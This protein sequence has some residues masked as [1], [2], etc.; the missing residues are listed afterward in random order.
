LN[1]THTKPTNKCVCPDVLHYIFENDLTFS[2]SNVDNNISLK[3]A[4]S[5]FF[6]KLFP[7]LIL[8]HNSRKRRW[9]K[10][11]HF[12][13]FWSEFAE[14]K[15]LFALSTSTWHVTFHLQILTNVFSVVPTV[16]MK[17]FAQ[18]P[19]AALLAPVKMAT[20]EMGS[21]RA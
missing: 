8:F 3:T 4:L 13:L 18:I 14:R 17:Q 1:E 2:G 15:I 19:S 6:I 12:Y 16:S 9:W 7:H 21:M 10:N 5:S 11:K 20:V